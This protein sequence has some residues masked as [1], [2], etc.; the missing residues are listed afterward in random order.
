MK[1]LLVLMLALSLIGLTGCKEDEKEKDIVEFDE[2]IQ[3]LEGDGGNYVLNGSDGASMPKVVAADVVHADLS[4]YDMIIDIRSAAYYTAGHINGAVNVALDQVVNYVETNGQADDKIL[5][6]C[7]SGQSAG[8]AVLALNLLG[9]NAYSLK[10]GMSSWHSSLDKWT[11]NSINSTD[12]SA[13]FATAVT[14]LPTEIIDYPVLNTGEK[15]GE[16]IL[17]ARI[18]SML[19]AGFKS[20][21]AVDLL[22]V[23]DTYFIINYFGA[24]DYD[25]TSGKCP[26][27]HISGAY[28]FTPGSSFQTTGSLNKIPTDKNVVVYCWTGQTS[29]QAVAFLNVL[30]YTSFSLSW[31]V[32]GMV[33]S[34]LT[35]GKWTASSTHDYELVQ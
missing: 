27:G 3:Y 10:F 26:A 30:G 24:T 21:K 29:S 9:Y 6:A 4:V 8:H 15:T 32:N 16:D 19:T 23:K 7:Y 35:S 14:A 5:V 17:R 25:G 1:R 11:A 12:Y 33:Y 28:Q 18:D 13:H 2:L 34:T 31:G 22:P 20:K